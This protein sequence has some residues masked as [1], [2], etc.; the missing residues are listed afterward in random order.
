M[1]FSPVQLREGPQN[2]DSFGHAPGHAIRLFRT[3]EPCDLTYRF[4]SLIL[5]R[6]GRRVEVIYGPIVLSMVSV[7]IQMTEETRKELFPGGF[8]PFYWALLVYAALI[9]VACIVAV[10]APGRKDWQLW[11]YAAVTHALICAAVA[12]V[13]KVV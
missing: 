13:C 1:N 5:G 3:T 7:K 12:A 4:C 6:L 9:P 10:E 11:S 8:K 2:R